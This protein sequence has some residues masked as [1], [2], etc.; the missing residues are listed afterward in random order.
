MMLENINKAQ[1]RALIARRVGMASSC[2]MVKPLSD[3]INIIIGGSHVYLT[4]ES[5]DRLRHTTRKTVHVL[6]KNELTKHFEPIVRDFV[7]HA[8]FGAINANRAME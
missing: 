4:P 1:G 6:D 5:A 2:S 3:L 8:S 7:Y